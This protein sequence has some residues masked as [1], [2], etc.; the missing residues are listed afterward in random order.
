MNSTTID[1]IWLTIGAFSILVALTFLG[2]VLRARQAPETTNPVLE[3]YMTRV[4]SWWAMV[5]FIGI[6]M[7]TGKVGVTILFAVASFAALRE[8]LT[9][10]SKA[11]ADHLSLAMAFFAV[12]P[13]QY[14][15]VAMEWTGLYAVFIPVY[16][17]LLLPIVSALRGNADRFLIRVAETQWALMIAVFCVSHVPA[18]INLDIAGYGD[19]AILLV[20][21]LVMVVQLG[22]LLEYFFGRRIGR[23]KIAPGLSPKTWEGVV[24]GVISAMLIGALLSWITPFGVMGAIA[25]AGIASIVG[26]FG[27]IVFAAIKRDRGVKDWSHLIPG[28]GGFVDQLDSVV[29]AAPIFYHL[30]RYFWGG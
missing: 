12:L 16:A 28:Q 7:L 26:M 2:E 9:L 30:T 18:L 21:F 23:T 11:Q 3:T 5:A 24:C 25:M 13:L 15:F 27:N 8:F 4:Q 20:T 6:A 14:I 17:F 1:I 19:R 10:T 29:F 22:D